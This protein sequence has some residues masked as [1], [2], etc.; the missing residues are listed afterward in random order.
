[1]A[2]WTAITRSIPIAILAASHFE[3]FLSAQFRINA[4]SIQAVNMP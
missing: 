4:A 1:M 3:K 2:I